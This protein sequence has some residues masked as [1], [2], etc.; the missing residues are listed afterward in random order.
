MTTQTDNNNKSIFERFF[1]LYNK[2]CTEQDADSL[3]NLL[4]AIHSLN[5]RLN[6][7]TGD[8]F[9]QNNEFISIKALR[10]LFHHQDELLNELK[11]L[12]ANRFPEIYSDL[13]FLCLVPSR[14][15]EKSIESIDKKYKKAQTRIIHSTFHWYG[16][17]VNIY[18]CLFNFSVKV[19]E[20][21]NSLEIDLDII[22][23]LE[24]KESYDFESENGH[25]HYV[26]GKIS[27]HANQVDDVL[28]S[29]FENVE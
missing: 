11:I 16:E 28:M 2:F 18:P 15:V 4:N 13:I 7:S 17:V 14:L 10:N 20:K 21:A 1:R 8:N 29:V 25:P 24:F 23:Y 6:K 27:C 22:E 3:F 12:P 5:D 19:F 26:D 9:F